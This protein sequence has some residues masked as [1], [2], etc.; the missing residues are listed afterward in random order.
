[1]QL[2]EPNYM[3]GAMYGDVGFRIRS[4]QTAMPRK[5]MK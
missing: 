3:L 4:I 5:T 1:V 2:N